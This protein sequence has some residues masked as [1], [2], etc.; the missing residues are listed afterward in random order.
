MADRRKID[1]LA[2]L[3]LGIIA[4]AVAA[5]G[6]KLYF[7]LL[8]IALLMGIVAHKRWRIR[9]ADWREYQSNWKRLVKI[10]RDK[11]DDR[12]TTFISG[13]QR[14]EPADPPANPRDPEDFFVDPQ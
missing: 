9:L 2:I 12:L 13:N 7:L 1:F 11:P 8:P 4:S 5:F 3:F 10:I 14:V 6:L